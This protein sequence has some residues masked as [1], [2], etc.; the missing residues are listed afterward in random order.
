M[1]SLGTWIKIYGKHIGFPVKSMDLLRKICGYRWP[2]FPLGD[3]CECMEPIPSGTP[4]EFF[5]EALGLARRG[6]VW[7]WIS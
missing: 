6:M 1:E 3:I 4:L 5:G 7:V 2:W